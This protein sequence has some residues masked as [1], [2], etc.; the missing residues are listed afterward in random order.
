VG[1]IVKSIFR[2][3]VSACVACFGFPRCCSV[4]K[5]ERL[6]VDL[7]RKS[8]PNFVLFDPP[9]VKSREGVDEISKR[10][11]SEFQQFGIGLNLYTYDRALRG[12]LED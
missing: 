9:R 8:R 10:Y 12:H 1:K 2:Q 11:L 6:T 4:S 5:P 3:I 7:G